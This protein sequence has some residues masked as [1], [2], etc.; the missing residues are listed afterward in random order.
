MWQ[1][2]EKWVNEEVEEFDVNEINNFT[3]KLMEQKFE[4]KRYRKRGGEEEDSDD[5]DL[6]GWNYRKY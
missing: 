1:L 3:A 4:K 2:P 6:N 5:D